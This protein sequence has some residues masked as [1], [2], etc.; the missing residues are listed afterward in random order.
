[1]YK[2]SILL[3]D[4]HSWWVNFFFCLQDLICATCLSTSVS[5][6]PVNVYTEDIICDPSQ[7]FENRIVIPQLLVASPHWIPICWSIAPVVEA[8]GPSPSSDGPVTHEQKEH[9]WHSIKDTTWYYQGGEWRC[10]GDTWYTTKRQLCNQWQRQ[11]MTIT[12]IN[13]QQ[14]TFCILPATNNQQ[15]AT[16]SFQVYISSPNRIFFFNSCKCRKRIIYLTHRQYRDLPDTSWQR[17]PGPAPWGLRFTSCITW[18][19]SAT[20]KKLV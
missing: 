2:L 8:T 1:M 20:Q 4:V 15:A 18:T 17:I 10:E 12:S 5:Q 11:Q 14:G 9:A 13:E 19:R 3:S 6:K 16:E 7:C